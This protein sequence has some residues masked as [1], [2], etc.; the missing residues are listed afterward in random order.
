MHPDLVAIEQVLIHHEKGIDTTDRRVWERSVP[1]D[2]PSDESKTLPGTVAESEDSQVP[3]ARNA[4]FTP[5]Y[6]GEH[7]RVRR[8]P[9]YYTSEPVPPEE[10]TTLLSP[11]I[12]VVV[13]VEWDSSI[14]W[15]WRRWFQWSP[16]RF[17]RSWKSSGGGRNLQFTQYVLSVSPPLLKHGPNN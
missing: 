8:A 10:A 14:A 11:D 17:R 1:D 13:S 2:M 16:L 5:P 4:S 3:I 6:P 9:F 12:N 7:R 15:D